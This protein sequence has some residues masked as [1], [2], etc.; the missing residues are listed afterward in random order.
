M[1]KTRIGNLIID[2]RYLIIDG[3][4]WSELCGVRSGPLRMDKTRIGNLIID[5]PSSA[6][7]G[8]G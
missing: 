6:N 1:D 7:P 2:G 5:G 8:R 3:P 4:S